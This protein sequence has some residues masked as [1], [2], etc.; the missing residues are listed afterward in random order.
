MLLLSLVYTRGEI[1]ALMK[2]LGIVLLTS[3]RS[4]FQPR[5]RW[6]TSFQLRV[7]D[8]YSL[9]SLCLLYILLHII[10]FLY[11]LFCKGRSSSGHVTFYIP[12]SQTRMLCNWVEAP[13]SKGKGSFPLDGYLK[14]KFWLSI[15][16][17]IVRCDGWWLEIRRRNGNCWHAYNHWEVF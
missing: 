9:H 1:V 8:S 10:L 14:L 6:K 15:W 11:N 2:S 16:W 3:V 4:G 7:A 17:N 12:S 13:N 5:F